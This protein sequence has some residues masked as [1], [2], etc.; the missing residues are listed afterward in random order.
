MPKEMLSKEIFVFQ[1]GVVFG[2][3]QSRFFSSTRIGILKEKETRRKRLERNFLQDK[4]SS[5]WII[6]IERKIFSAVQ[7]TKK[8]VSRNFFELKI[9]RLKINNK[10]AEQ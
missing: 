8:K 4:T 7:E 1:F 2:T 10:N 9:K 3:V 6:E 5:Y